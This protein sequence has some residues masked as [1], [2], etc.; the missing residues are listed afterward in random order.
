MYILFLKVY[1]FKKL[2]SSFL[3]TY[4]NLYD[5]HPILWTASANPHEVT[6]AVIQCKML[7]G[8]YRTAMLTKHWSSNKSGW[9][10]SPCCSAVEETLEHL[11]L[12]CPMYEQVRETMFR[13]WLSTEDPIVLQILR[14]VLNGPP[15]SL[16]KFILDASTHPAVVSLC[17]FQGTESLYVIFHLTRSWCFSIHKERAKLRGRFY[18]P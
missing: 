3:K 8:R 1:Y 12:W 18:F 14:F 10:P 5:P 11:L 15:D 9:C 6:K 2:F 17:Q 13:L 4:D 16:L 7:S